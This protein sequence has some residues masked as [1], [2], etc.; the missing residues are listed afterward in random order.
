M[1]NNSL[2]LSLLS[3]ANT[4]TTYVRNARSTAQNA[5]NT[6]A[7]TQVSVSTDAAAA[8]ALQTVVQ[9]ST[10]SQQLNNT[11]NAASP[12]S[13]AVTSASAQYSRQ[14]NHQASSAVHSAS[15]RG[16]VIDTTA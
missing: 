8:S 11:S 15:A 7:P 6:S 5:P 3:I 1:S 12:T 16:G 13:N 10:E 9:Q 2:S 4:Q 14:L